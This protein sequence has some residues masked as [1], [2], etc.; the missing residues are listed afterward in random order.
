M[1]LDLGDENSDLLHEALLRSSTQ[2]TAVA[3]L[4]PLNEEA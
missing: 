1:I 4:V 2:G 3:N